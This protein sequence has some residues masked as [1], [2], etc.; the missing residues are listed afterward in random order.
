MYE[1]GPGVDPDSRPA[2]LPKFL[3]QWMAGAI[4]FIATV[5]SVK[6][7]IMFSGIIHDGD[8]LIL[9]KSRRNKIV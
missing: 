3:V 2:S 7:F 8:D 9:L 6:A 1:G 5:L 4:S